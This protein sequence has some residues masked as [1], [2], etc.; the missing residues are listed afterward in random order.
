M[1]SYQTHLEIVFEACILLQS[2]NSQQ[3]NPSEA[4][5]RI[6]YFAK[7]NTILIPIMLKLSLSIAAKQASTDICTTSIRITAIA[8]SLLYAQGA[9][10]IHA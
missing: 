9:H 6:I 2:L 8:I 7:E 3:V 5:G 4:V 1:C 10:K